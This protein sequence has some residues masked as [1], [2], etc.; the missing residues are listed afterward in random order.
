MQLRN[1]DFNLLLPLRALLEERSVSRAAERMHMSQPALSA[2]LGRLRRHF[3]DELLE[4]RGNNY[5]LTPLAAQLLDRSYSA[6]LSMER[7]FSAQ[8]E[9]DPTTSTREFSI[10]SSDYGM[11]V[12]GGGLA[13]VLAEA[14]P[15]VRI[16]FHSITTPAVTNAPDSLRDYDGLF[17]PHGYLNIPHQDMFCDRWVCIVDAHNPE[18]GESLRLE[19]LSQLPWVFTFS[20]PSEYTPASK[21]MQMLGIEPRVQIVTPSFLALPSLLAGSTRIALVQESVA[22]N[23]VQDGRMRML[24]C[25]FDVVPLTETFWWNPV[26]ERDPEHVWLRS[27]LPLA[28]ERAGLQAAPEV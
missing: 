8:A 19:Q 20:G 28:V 7:I 17:M 9:F 2:A 13:E 16:R 26:H 11:S 5:E 1:V 10:F 3:G 24:E 21:Q 22:R 4:R 12:L 25:P 27:L 23:M 15:G 18:V 14:A 6:T